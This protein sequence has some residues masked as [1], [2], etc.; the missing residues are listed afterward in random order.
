MTPRAEVIAVV[1]GG[2]SGVLA[3]IH[4]LRDAPVP[5]RILIIEPRGELGRGI[6]YGTDDLGHL[7]NVRAGCLSVLPT[8]PT[9]SRHGPGEGGAR[10]TVSR[11]CPG[12]G[13]ACTSGPC[14]SRS[15]TSRPA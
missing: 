10:S 8:S 15:S 6:A 3:A 5:V 13:T 12:R 1:G 9:T 7:L 4:L 2:A 11:S 14:S